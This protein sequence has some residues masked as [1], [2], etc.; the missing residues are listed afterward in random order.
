VADLPAKKRI[1]QL[2][3]MLSSSGG[4][5]KN[6]FTALERLMAN[7]AIGWSDIGNAIERGFDDNYTEA[8]MQEY[9]QA[10]RAEGIEAGIAI[11]LAR[12]GNGSG[13]GHLTLP[14]PADMAD[15]CQ[16][17][18]SRLKNDNERKF[19]TEVYVITQRGRRLF[20]G[21]LGY[22]ASLYIKNGGSI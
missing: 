7:E 15:F 22:L 8:E 6:A 11:G 19:V 10:A 5:R 20:P 17:R 13:N 4:E 2:F 9:R 16:Q 12:A 3:R 14:K 18:L 21:Q 1:A